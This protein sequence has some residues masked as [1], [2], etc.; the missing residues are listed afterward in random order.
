MKKPRDRISN[1]F[2]TAG[3]CV[4]LLLLVASFNFYAASENHT[5]L[6]AIKITTVQV[7]KQRFN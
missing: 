7:A 3:S 1:T 6:A 5:I 2:S 4:V